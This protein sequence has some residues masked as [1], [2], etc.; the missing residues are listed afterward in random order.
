MDAVRRGASGVQPVRVPLS[1]RAHATA[2]VAAAQ[3]SGI[4]RGPGEP[5]PV[6]QHGHEL[7]DEHE[8][9]VVRRRVDDELSRPD[10][11]PG[12]PELRLGGR[13]DCGGNRHDPRL[14]AP[15]GQHDRQ[16]LGGPDPRDAVRPDSDLDRRGASAV[17]TGRDPELPPL[18]R[19]QDRRRRDPDDRARP[20][21]VAGGHQAAR[22]ERRRLLQ[23]Q[24]VPPVRESDPVHEPRADPADLRARRRAHLHVRPHGE[25]H[26][27]G[28]GALLGHVGH[29][30]HRRVR[31]VSG[32]ASR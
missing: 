30:P 4:R 25:G 6:V 16:L 3:S 24:L 5:R 8:L 13:R 21:G 32:R 15:R 29:V 18:H 11:G 20:G 2:R 9:A 10:G 22:H 31:G 23:R 28:L 7:H 1:I 12:R 19:R 14:R 26:A 27:P 17:L